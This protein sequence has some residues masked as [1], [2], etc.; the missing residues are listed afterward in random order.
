M[1]IILDADGALKDPN[2]RDAVGASKGQC[3]KT[4]QQWISNPT[5]GSSG[6]PSLCIVS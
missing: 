5:Q 2:G 1:L 4:L 6:S 3:E